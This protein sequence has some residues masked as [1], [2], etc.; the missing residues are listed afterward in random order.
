MSAL[1]T[2]PGGTVDDTLSAGTETLVVAM[3]DAGVELIVAVATA[4][5][6]DAPDGGLRMEA[7]EFPPFLREV[8]A[9]HRR[10]Y[11]TLVDSGLEWTLVCPPNMP[12]GPATGAARVERDRLPE[13]GTRVTTGDVAAFVV[14]A[15]EGGPT[16][17]VGIAE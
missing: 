3:R 10:A 13:G 7:P 2:P 8:A 17:R 5:V 11:G 15:L 14:R 9:E 4:G 12:D 16:G 6:L 1:G